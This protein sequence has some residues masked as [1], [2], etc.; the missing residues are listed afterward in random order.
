MALC[1]VGRH[2]A[3][4]QWKANRGQVPRAGQDPKGLCKCVSPR[5]R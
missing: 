1:P 3:H 2:T 5:A 4:V